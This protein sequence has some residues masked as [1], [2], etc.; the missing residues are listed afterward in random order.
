[1][2]II[3]ANNNKFFGRWDSDFNTFRKSIEVFSVCKNRSIL[4][5]RCLWRQSVRKKFRQKYGL[6]MQNKCLYIIKSFQEINNRH[7]WRLSNWSNTFQING[8]LW[9][10]LNCFHI[11]SHKK[12]IVW[13]HGLNWS[14]YTLM[15]KTKLY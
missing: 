1:M 9:V 10:F 8:N 4:F 5:L 2:A 14:F 11:N 13:K 3:E 7:S 12:R 6:F 15:L